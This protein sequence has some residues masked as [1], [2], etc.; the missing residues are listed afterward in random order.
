LENFPKDQS[1]DFVAMVPAQIENCLLNNKAVCMLQNI[2]NLIIGGAPLSQQTQQAISQLPCKAYQ[3][4]GMT[5][6]VSHIALAKITG[7]PPLVYR[8]L[9]GVKISTTP[10]GQLTIDAPMALETLITNDIVEIISENQFVW[11]GRAD[12]TINSG[13]IKIQPEILEA[14]ISPIMAKYL[15]Q[16]RYFISGRPSKKWGEEIILIVESSPSG[17]LEKT[18][19]DAIALVAGKYEKPKKIYFLENFTETPS[20]KIKRK[21]N[22]KM[23][24]EKP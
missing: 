16:S 4:Y 2:A 15:P 12:F 1:F 23:V 10:S 18:L 24:L 19:N 8:S 5:E 13:G 20:G 14:K 17:Q 7:K 11:K 22:L 6:T 9:P 21:D 3:T